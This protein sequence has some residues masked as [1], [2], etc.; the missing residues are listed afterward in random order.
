MR[1]SAKKR[2]QITATGLWLSL[3]GC[4]KEMR[5]ALKPIRVT[6]AVVVLVAACFG[7]SFLIANHRVASFFAPYRNVIK[8]SRPSPCLLYERFAG[9][10]RGFWCATYCTYDDLECCFPPHFY[11]PFIGAAVGVSNPE[12][13][14][15]WQAKSQQLSAMSRTCRA[16]LDRGHQI[17]RLSAA[18]EVEEYSYKRE[19]EIRGVVLL[20]EGI[21]VT[22]VLDA[23]PKRPPSRGDPK[24]VCWSTRFDSLWIYDG[25]RREFRRTA[26]G[27]LEMSTGRVYAKR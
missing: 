19:G 21:A 17:G 1:T 8:W 25:G 11:A 26:Q 27:L 15:H 10:R 24:N 14:A 5:R 22:N 9:E 2:D 23:T 12:R 4:V 13:L 16:K 7:I 18:G 3:G 20:D 6:C